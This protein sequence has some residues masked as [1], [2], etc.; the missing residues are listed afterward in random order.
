MERTLGILKPDCLLRKFMGKVI[1]RLEEEGFTIANGM[2]KRLT[3]KEAEGFYYVHKDRAFFDDLVEFMTSGPVFI[4]LLEREN[5]IAKLREVIG[6]TD[7]AQA[8]SGTI[9]RE[10][11]ESKQNNLIGR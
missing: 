2:I 7:P 11:A 5:A 3:R 9:R 10:L 6:D 8:A 1:N 4:M